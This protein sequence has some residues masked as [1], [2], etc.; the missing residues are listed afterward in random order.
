MDFPIIPAHTG[1]VFFDTLKIYLDPEDPAERAAL[2]ASGVVPRMSRLNQAVR[3]AGIPVFFPMADHRPDGRDFAPHIADAPF[4]NPPGQ[5]PWK[6]VPPP[7]R[8]GTRGAE[9]LDDLT[10]SPDDYF[11]KKH[12]WSSFFQTHLELSLRTAGI[13]TLILSGGSVEVGVASTAYAARDRDFNLIIARDACT[14]R[15]E[16]ANVAFMDLIFPAFARVMTVDQIIAAI[17]KG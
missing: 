16:A 13:D 4:H 2:Q 6:T 1:M 5:G 3:A 14:A 17:A 12:R 9:V 7:V 8:G 10:P 11:I 15:F